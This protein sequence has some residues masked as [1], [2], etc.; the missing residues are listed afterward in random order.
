MMTGDSSPNT[1]RWRRYLRFWRSNIRADVE[2]E[3][4]FHVHE[5]IDELVALGMDPQTAR[6]EARRRFGDIERVK[7]T[8][9]TLAQQQEADMRRAE[10]LDVLRQDVVYA[11]RTMRS[12]VSFTAAIVLTLAL[13]I[14]ATTAIFSVV[15]AVLLRPLPYVDADRMVIIFERFGDGRGNASVGHYHDWAEQSRSFTAMSAF[16][17]RTYT[18]A[19][20]EP[21]RIVG[22]RV[23]PSFFQTGYM[24]PLLGRYFLP[25]ETEASRVVVLSYPLWQSRYA[26]DPGIVGKQITLNGEKHTAIGVTPAAYTLTTLDEKLWVPLTFAPAMRTNYGAHFL[27]VFAKLKPNVTLAQAQGEVERITED[28]RRREPENMKDRGVEAALFR[29]VLIRDYRTQLFVLL[30]AVTFVLLIGCGNVASLLLARATTRRKEIAIRGALGGARR[31][32][33]RQLLT[34]SLLLSAFGGVAGLLVARLAIHFLKATGPAFV[35][36]LGEAGLQLEVL[37]FAV[38]ATV[39]CG[40]LFGLAPAL[41]ATRVDLQSELREGGRGSQALTRDRTRAALITTEIAV[42][43]VLL[44]SAALFVRSAQRLQSVP[45]GFEPSGVTMMR[46]ALSPDRYAEPPAI[47][48][49]F[50]RVV[51]QVRAIPGVEMAAAGTRV[52]MWGGSVDFGVTVDGRPRA[53]KPDLGHLRL[54]TAGFLETL[55]M[56]LLRGRLLRASDQASGAP[57]VVVVNETFARNLFGTEDPI[58]QR[59]SG[60]TS[61]DKPEWREIVGVVGDVRSFGQANDIPP[62]IYMPLTQ[63]PGGAW[64]ALQRNMTVVARSRAGVAVAPA[65]RRAVS[66]VDPLLPTYDVQTMDDVLAQSTSTRR[67]NTM[68]LSLLGLTGLVLATIGIYGVIA[69]FVSQRTH[70]IGVRVALGA[71]TQSVVRMVV[72]QALSLAVLGIAVGGVASFWATRVLGTMLFQVSARDPVAFAVAAAA[73]FLVAIGASWLPARRAARVDPVRALASA[74]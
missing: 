22:A 61:S 69:Y 51:D 26:G 32:L 33:V 39:G 21:T 70:E 23:T 60:W 16:Q 55:H 49:A 64:N 53:E 28:I 63:A 38:V 43:L 44:V 1:P 48:A 74:G 57:W 46:I 31:R 72:L 42:A 7:E 71:T 65:M 2:D 52:P 29:D 3:F 10:A 14:G 6:A 11:L 20:G 56:R 50:T 4:Q 34:E 30:G 8:C 41:R 73:L 17:F 35:P 25:N 66:A 18:V 5:R 68:L 62:E 54:V 13:G 24:R 12:N 67:F 19:D 27:T 36:R 9:R 58:G 59:I 40:L 47:E 15:N 37:L 45:L